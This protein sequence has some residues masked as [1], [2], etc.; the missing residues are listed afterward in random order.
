[1]SAG[2][3]TFAMVKRFATLSTLRSFLT[4][5]SDLLLILL[6]LALEERIATQLAG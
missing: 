2:L 5:L 1:M 4:T 6:V 3:L